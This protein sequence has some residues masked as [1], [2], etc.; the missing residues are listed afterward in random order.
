VLRASGGYRITVENRR[1]VDPEALLAALREVAAH[2]E[3]E[4]RAGGRDAA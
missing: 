2:V 3:D 1:G 4:I